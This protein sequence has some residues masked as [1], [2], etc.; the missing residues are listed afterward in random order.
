MMLPRNAHE[1]KIYERLDLLRDLYSVTIYPQSARTTISDAQILFDAEIASHPGL[2]SRLRVEAYVVLHHIFDY[3]LVKLQE[4]RILTL[5]A[6]E[7]EK[8]QFL[9]PC[10]GKPSTSVTSNSKWP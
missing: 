5:N 8:V 4:N 6:V 3:A 9:K 2:H 10:S 1:I 7:A